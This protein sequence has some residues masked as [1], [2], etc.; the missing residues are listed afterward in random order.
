L[1]RDLIVLDERSSHGHDRT[2]I[3]TAFTPLL[4]IPDVR[5]GYSLLLLTRYGRK[6]ASS[7][8][9]HYGYLPALERAGFDVTIAPF[10]DDGHIDRLYGGKRLSIAALIKAYAGRFRQLVDSKRY[11]LLWIEKEALPW[12]PAS[13]ER[14]L[15]TRGTYVVDY[16]D[17]W[18]LRYAHHSRAMVR[19]LIGRKLE[20]LVAGAALVVAG[21]SALANWASSSGA[22]RVIELPSCIDLDRYSVSPLPEGPFT[23]GWI[24]TPLTAKYLALVAEP[25]RHLQANHGARLIA[26]GTGDDFSLPGVTMERISWSEETE[27]AALARCH[28]GIAPLVDGMW[29]RG[30]CGYKLA[31]YMAV[32]RAT[33]ASPV[34]VNASIVVHGQTGFL[35]GTAKE[36]ID[37]LCALASNPALLTNFGVNGRRRA[38]EMYSLQVTSSKLVEA[39]REAASSGELANS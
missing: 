35:A 15:L 37:S 22:H 23:I 26:I 24:G 5:M 17:A 11:D 38:E 12:L 28:V 30:K 20:D 10:F 14:A 19:R 39:L 8:V 13:L 32:G 36:W 9:R 29:E 3:F 16:D 33:I 27:V 21:N 2:P 4:K 7:R 18:Y 6:G 1:H 34:G 25:I 31:Q